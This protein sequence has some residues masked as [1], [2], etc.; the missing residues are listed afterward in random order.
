[1]A[2]P[3]DELTT[4][5]QVLPPSDTVT[6]LT[7]TPS[8][9]MGPDG[10][11]DDDR[12]SFAELGDG[13]YSVSL[14]TLTS[15]LVGDYEA[16]FFVNNTLDSV[17]ENSAY[18]HVWSVF[19]STSGGQVAETTGATRREIRRSVA[20][21]LSDLY[22]ATA[23][24]IGATTSMTDSRTFARESSHFKG[25]QVL[26]TKPDSPHYGQIV[27]V[28]NSD[29][30]TRTINFEPPLTSLVEPG[31]TVEMVNFRGRGTTISQYNG[32]IND[33]IS[34]ARQQHYILPYLHPVEESFSRVTPPIAIPAFFIS[35][36]GITTVERNGRTYHVQPGEYRVDRL[37]KTVE[38]TRN[39]TIERLNGL[40]LT[41]RGYV[42]PSLLTSDDD[43]TSIDLE[44]LYNETKAAILERMVA[45]GMP[46]QTA[47]RLYLQEREQSVGKR[48][49]IMHR[50]VPNTI[51]MM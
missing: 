10:P 42:M 30:P 29:G 15:D 23:T 38:I 13:F 39:S 37:A 21:M 26:F 50:A 5:I 44:W 17:P 45:S 27:T 3:G 40:N 12:F 25:M 8:L 34:A 35:F 33:A 51:R 49:L 24:T 1:M 9:L 19:A 32:A 31:D 43:R 20:R 18:S 41:L 36:A 48:T 28:T 2:I 16:H 22:E 46:I 11:L 7:V 14:Q 47:D 4:Y 6:G